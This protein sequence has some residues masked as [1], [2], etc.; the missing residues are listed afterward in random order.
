[1]RNC[2]LERCAERAPRRR[3]GR[4]KGCAA[5]AATAGAGAVAVAGGRRRDRHDGER[6][7]A[8]AA[9]ANI[10]TVTRHLPSSVV[11]HNCERRGFAERRNLCR[12]ALRRALWRDC[13]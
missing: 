3:G 9:A 13:D 8:T 5:A 12:E 7:V 2:V 1:M 10:I 6:H 11:G 4:P